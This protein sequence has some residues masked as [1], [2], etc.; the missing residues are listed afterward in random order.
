MEEKLVKQIQE[1]LILR[2]EH[3]SDYATKSS[4]GIR[5]KCE[6]LNNDLRPNFYHDIDDRTRRSLG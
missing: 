5:I 1:N 4:E 3:L 2:E 6:D